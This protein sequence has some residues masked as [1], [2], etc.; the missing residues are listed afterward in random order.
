MVEAVAPAPGSTPMT[1]PI[2]EPTR[3][4]V[5][6]ATRSRICGSMER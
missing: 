3:S 5:F 6:V 1:K 4:E 2:S